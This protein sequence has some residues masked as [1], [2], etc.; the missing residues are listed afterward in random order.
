M[1]RITRVLP[2]AMAAIMLLSSGIHASALGAGF[3]AT[4][5]PDCVVPG[6]Q[7]TIRVPYLVA[8]TV[9]SVRANYTDSTAGG[10]VQ[11]A[12]GRANAQ[13]VFTATITIPTTATSGNGSLAVFLAAGP[14]VGTF[15]AEIGFGT[16]LIRTGAG[17]CPSPGVATIDGTHFTNAVGY[18]VKKT[19]DAGVTGNA[20]FS[21]SAMVGEAGRFLF[22][23]ITLACNG[24]AVTLPA[25]PIF[26]STVTLH[27][28]TP[29]TGA[30]AAADTVFTLPPA[31]QPVTI[32]NAKAAAAATPTPVV[33]LAGTGGGSPPELAPLSLALVLLALVLLAVA[34]IPRSSRE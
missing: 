10:G 2:A 31:S 7:L 29:A 22:P 5:A 17:A 19:C 20:V 1:I 13:G 33:Q 27:E 9:M 26:A 11:Y 34:S 30:T 14:V 8:G 32:H 24:A 4:V 28:T 12:T 23:P 21:M 6:Q 15:E 3:Q 25:L 18:D 16:F